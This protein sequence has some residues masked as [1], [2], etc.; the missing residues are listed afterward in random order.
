MAASPNVDFVSGA[1]YTA[2][3]ANKFPRGIMDYAGMSS[4]YVLTT[5]AVALTT[6]TFTAV[7][8]RAYKFTYFEP[9]A[10]TGSGA[11]NSTTLQI[12]TGA[13]AAGTLLAEG[14]LQNSAAAQITG[15]VTVSYIANATL[16][17]GSLTFNVSA[18][19][20]STT[21]APNLVRAATSRAFLLV[22]DLGPF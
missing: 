17:A 11:G 16:A 9:K 22:E 19:T 20:S 14:L 15:S 13:T 18:L 3:Q 21:G 10:Q 7:A 5:S 12:R 4:N 2:S 8:N 6:V 1:I